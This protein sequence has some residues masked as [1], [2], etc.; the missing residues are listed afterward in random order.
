MEH[1]G[2]LV[3]FQSLAHY[4]YP[5]NL[6]ILGFII[7]KNTELPAFPFFLT[8]LTS[9]HPLFALYIWDAIT[10]DLS[11]VCLPHMLLG[12][13]EITKTAAEKAGKGISRI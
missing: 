11:I 3:L 6:N 4:K 13:P 7:H 2:I 12:N 1:I 10:A 5:V 9:F 8:L